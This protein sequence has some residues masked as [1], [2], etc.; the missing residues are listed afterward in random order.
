MATMRTIGSI[1]GLAVGATLV[2]SAGVV[3]WGVAPARAVLPG[4]TDTT[5]TY[6][7]VAATLMNPAALTSTTSGPLVLRN[8]PITVTHRTRVLATKGGNALVSDAKS[9]Q[10]GGRTVAAVDQRYAVDRT[11]LTRGSGYPDVVE[12]SG[13]TF[14]WPIRAQAHDYTGWVSDTR[15]TAPLH[16]TGRAERGGVPTYVFTTTTAPAAITDPQVLA[17]LPASEPKAALPQ[18]AA[19]L[20][21]PAAQLAQLVSVLPS[22]PD[23][24][25]LSYTYQVSATYWVQP[26]SGIVVDL[27]QHEVRTLALDV[28]GLA[29]PVTRVMDISFTSPAATLAAAAADARDRGN[30]VTL[31]YG[32]LPLGLLVAGLVLLLAGGVARFGFGGGRRT[33][34]HTPGDDPDHPR[35][36]P[37]DGR[38]AAG[39]AGGA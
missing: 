18:L 3:R 5:R 35:D 21:L 7:G 13:I 32:R 24:V 8:V 39:V 25:R 12:Q 37:T 11:D 19:G 16:Y 1:V 36:E 17:S 30:A 6:T 2:L 22:L 28:A 34:G 20:D 33:P 29:V 10:A 15:R 14:N 27:E 26:S 31:I 4:D 23:P 38:V 9:V